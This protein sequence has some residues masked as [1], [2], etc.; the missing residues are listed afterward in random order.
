MKK[1]PTLA[2]LIAFATGLGLGTYASAK[3][4]VLEG[5]LESAIKVKKKIQFSID[6]TIN[7]L[8]YRL[9]LPMTFSNKAMRQDLTKMN[10]HYEPQPAQIEDANDGFGNCYKKVIWRNLSKDVHITIAFD[11]KVK[12]ELPAMES[13]A[14]FP[15]RY[16]PPEVSIYLQPTKFVQ[17]ESKEI[18]TLSKQLTQAVSTEYEA[19]TA[20][21]NYVTDTVKYTYN[22]PE[23]DALYTLTMRTGNCT[24]IAHLSLALLRAAG[25]PARIVT[26]VSLNKHWKVPVEDYQFLIPAMGQGAHAWIEI[27]FTD[28]G[29]LSY[30][31]KQSK[32]FTSS[33]HIK[34]THGLDYYDIVGKWT[35]RPYVPVFTMT[36]DANF[37][38]DVIALSPKHFEPNPES[39]MFSN[40]LVP[41]IEIAKKEPEKKKPDVEKPKPVEESKLLPSEHKPVKGTLVEFGNMDFPNLVDTYKII[42]NTGISIPD[43]ET[44]EYVTSQYVYAQAFRVEEPI[45]IKT[46]SLAMHKFGGDG[47]IYVDIVSDQNGRPGM[48]GTRSRP[49]F[50][51]DI[52]EKRG[53]Y[54][55]E[56]QLHDDTPVFDKGK[57]WI[58]LR[59]SGEVVITW[60]FIPGKSYSGPNDTRSTTK[61]YRWEDILGFDFVF[62][63]RG[64]RQ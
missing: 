14:P 50:L 9:P 18:Q 29:W 16:I 30:D 33:R 49:I 12:A 28:L 46:L 5:K 51:E 64:V 13:R 19:V 60:F 34:E 8:T 47:A 63:V 37:T 42:G 25:I 3:T 35:G 62:K 59:H 53:Y 26:G 38:E 15:L 22:P 61:G 41:L 43:T 1:A 2:L 39:Y 11:T 17:S 10:I 58:V 57:Y 55:V 56:F 21:I 44:A 27:Y 6:R 45:V 4:I 20:I 32:Q 24:N 48:T 31:P 40:H 54:W 36:I 52:T 7:E 23:F